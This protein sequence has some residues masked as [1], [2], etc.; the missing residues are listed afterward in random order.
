LSPPVSVSGVRV[1]LTVITAVGTAVSLDEIRGCAD[2][3]EFRPVCCHEYEG[4]Q[5]RCGR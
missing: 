2:V 5:Q 1:S 4:L 3:L